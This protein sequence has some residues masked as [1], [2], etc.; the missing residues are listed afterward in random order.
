MNPN[1]N[2]SQLLSGEEVELKCSPGYF[3]EGN[4]SVTLFKQT[5]YGLLGGWKE[6]LPSC[7]EIRVCKG[8]EPL[9]LPHMTRIDGSDHDTF[10][11]SVTYKCPDTMHNHF[12][13]NNHT[14]KCKEDLTSNILDG[15][16]MHS[17]FDFYDDLKDTEL[18]PCLGKANISFVFNIR[19]FEL[20]Q[21]VLK[22][23]IYLMLTWKI[24]RMS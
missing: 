12:G 10:L 9:L 4:Q 14:F 17:E 1:K 5:C 22:D 13:K 18:S 19:I 8:K 21:S 20:L 16:I 15:Q 6:S 3:L 7:E 24:M 11:G 23:S 2:L